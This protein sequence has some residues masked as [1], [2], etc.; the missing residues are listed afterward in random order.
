M[1]KTILLI[2]VSNVDNLSQV[3]DNDH[4]YASILILRAHTKLHLPSTL[5]SRLEYKFFRLPYVSLV[6]QLLPI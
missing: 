2:S 3:V 5:N 1:D 6:H 4:A